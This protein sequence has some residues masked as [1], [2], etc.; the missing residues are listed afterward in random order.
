MRGGKRD[1]GCVLS[2]QLG[3][4]GRAAADVVYKEE[5]RVDELVLVEERAAGEA[6]MYGLQSLEVLGRERLVAA[7]EAPQLLLRP[8]CVSSED[9][10]E[11][12]AR[13]RVRKRAGH[14]G[15]RWRGGRTASVLILLSVSL[16]IAS[17]SRR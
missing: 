8:L 2:A 10:W 17:L 6:R 1:K 16:L 4:V 5:R 9:G 12:G 7:D 3:E 13:R 15:L 14:A 11:V